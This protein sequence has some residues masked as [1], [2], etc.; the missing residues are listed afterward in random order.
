MYFKFNPLNK[1]VSEIPKD[2]VD[3]LINQLLYADKYIKKPAIA[4]EKFNLEKEDLEKFIINSAGNLITQ[5][6]EVVSEIKRYVQTSNEEQDVIGLAE[7]I[8]ASSSA[9]DSLSKVLIQNK[10]ELAQTELK[11][12]D[13]AGKK[14]LLQGEF[15]ASMMLSR[16]EVIKNLFKD[17]GIKDKQI[18]IDVKP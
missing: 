3:D 13:I 17:S 5:S 18:T 15:N 12:L 6:L 2:N 11:K 4:A 7:L 16:D 1:D 8:K 14:E 10:K 9:L